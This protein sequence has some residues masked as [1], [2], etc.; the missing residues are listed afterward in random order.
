[1]AELALRHVRIHGHDVGYR[2]G[3]S[4][5]T[6]PGAEYVMP[7]VVPRF[8]RPWGDATGPAEV[9]MAARRELLLDHVGGPAAP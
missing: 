9:D 1:M 5:L 3:G 4:L 2:M 6:L 7:A 8:V